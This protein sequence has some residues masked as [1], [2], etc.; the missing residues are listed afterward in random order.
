[1]IVNVGAGEGYY[2]VGLARRAAGAQVVAFEIDPLRRLWCRKMAGANGVGLRSSSAAA[3]TPPGS[4]V[5]SP[6]VRPS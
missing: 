6:V 5:R 2:A 1:M 3:A 4:S